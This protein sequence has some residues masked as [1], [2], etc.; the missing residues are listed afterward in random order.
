[1]CKNKCC[2]QYKMTEQ[3]KEDAQVEF[4]EYVRDCAIKE[5][6]SLVT[7]PKDLVGAN[8]VNLALIPTSALVHM[9]LC[10]MNGAEKYGPFNWREKGKKVGYMTYLA[11]D[12]RHLLEFLDGENLAPDSLYHHLGHLM[13]STAVLLDAIEC[14]NAVDDRPIKG[15]AS[16]LLNMNIVDLK[17]HLLKKYG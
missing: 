10:M 14:G 12:L 2:G 17:Q 4:S 1:M 13:A 6:K 3:E 15:Q 8:K 9:A 7:N 11:A 5:S 16:E